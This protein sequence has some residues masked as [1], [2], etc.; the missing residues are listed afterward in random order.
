MSVGEEVRTEQ[1]RPQQSLGTAAARNLA[2]TTKSAP[3][4]QEIS[5]RWLLRMLPW[6]NVQGGTY[7]VNRRLSYAVGDGRV[8]F[9]KTGDRVEVIPAELRR[10]A[11]AAVVRG[12]RRAR[13]ARPT[14]P[15]A[16]V[17]PGRGDRLVRQPRPTRCTCWRTAGWRRSAPAPT[18]T[19]RSSE[20]SPTAPTSATRRSSTRTP[21]G[22]TPP[23]RPPPARCSC[24]PARTSSRSRSVPTSPARAPP[25][26][27]RDP[28]AAHQQVRREG[29]RP[30]GRP[31][32]R[33]RHPAHLRRLRRQPARVR[34]EH[35]PDRPAHPHAAW[36][37]STT[38]R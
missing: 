7:R 21:S 32:R 10:A 26:T 35:R 28:L 18:A 8:T 19:T 1:D 37:T 11:G 17:R 2:T 14:L 29:D 34:A 31:R 4:M 6:V 12:R 22:S 30:R 25:G 38:S 13:R 5:S 33:A 15:A 20:S 23:A 27:A 24:C 36:P 16:G 9:V 3:Q